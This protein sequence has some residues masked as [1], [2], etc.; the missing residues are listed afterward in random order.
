M[1]KRKANIFTVIESVPN[2]FKADGYI[3]APHEAT[4]RGV[5]NSLGPD[6]R[7]LNPTV[8][9]S[10]TLRPL[11]VGPRIIPIRGWRL[12]GRTSPTTGPSL[13]IRAKAQRW[14]LSGLKVGH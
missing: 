14:P 4:K 12:L 10:H 7:V 5:D 2:W 11:L 8:T 6:P 9:A 1:N 3:E 13:G